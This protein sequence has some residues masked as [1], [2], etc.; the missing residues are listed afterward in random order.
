MD[1]YEGAWSK[2]EGADPS[3]D[4]FVAELKTHNVSGAYTRPENRA[5]LFLWFDL[6]KRGRP[7]SEVRTI[8]WARY[9]AQRGK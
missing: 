2:R 7:P 6:W 5:D 9:K 8:L 3:I 4:L 1:A